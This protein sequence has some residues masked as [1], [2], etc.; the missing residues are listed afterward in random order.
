MGRKATKKKPRSLGLGQLSLVE[1]AICP[2]DQ[3]TSLVNSLVHRSEITYFDKHR[4]R[5][6]GH[7]TVHASLG[8]S[9]IDEFFL[10][11]LLG[12]TFSQPEPTLDFRA[13][14]HFVLRSLG[15]ID[16]KSNRGGS[17]YRS[18]RAAL[19]RLAGVT[20]ES[21]CFYDPVR[22][23]H[24][25]VAFGFLSYSLP[26]SDES[27]RAWRIVWD[28][29]FF[30]LCNA[31]GGRLFFDI[32]I[33]RELDAT[34]R[35]LF[36]FLSKVFWRRKL[37]GWFDVAALAHNVLGVSRSVSIRDVRAK[38][39]ARPIKRLQEIGVLAP[40]RDG[41]SRKKSIGV[42]EICFERGAYFD[43]STSRLSHRNASHPLLDQLLGLGLNATTAAKVLREHKIG[44]LQEWVDI[45]LAAKERHGV[46]FFRR[47]AAAYFLDNIKHAACGT[48]TAPDWWHELRREEVGA[49][50]KQGPAEPRI[51]S[52]QR[53][54]AFQNYLKGP[55]KETFTRLMQETFNSFVDGGQPVREA[56][57]SAVDA[58]RTHMEHQFVAEHPEWQ[59]TE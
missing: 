54:L 47:S 21:N 30:E 20:Y 10:W 49:H 46:S 5:T 19:R 55:A 26:R 33:Y 15:R 8:L 44:L 32:D 52:K 43:R 1:H 17:A 2:L 12:L 42:Y 22:G 58:V 45:T 11:G 57:K 40:D 38:K 14:P 36:L 4:H 37:S 6:I 41:L 48:R 16:E 7:G 59:A 23:E 18:F 53:E 28:P 34:T 35:R 3:K 9:S 39:L 31:T 25:D 24:R 56:R 29:L 51:D 27:S 13:T 50:A